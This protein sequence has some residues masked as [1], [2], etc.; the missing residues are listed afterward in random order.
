MSTADENI[1]KSAKCPKCSQR[2]HIVSEVA[3]TQTQFEK[4]PRIPEPR[5]QEPPFID[6][7]NRS[8]AVSREI[9][10]SK[11]PEMTPRLPTLA[12]FI[13]GLTYLLLGFW[14]IADVHSFNSAL[15]NAKAAPQEAAIGAIFAA[16]FIAGYIFAR[17]IEKFI[18]MVARA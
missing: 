4:E 10:D 12:A 8:Q 1:G 9:P 18:R 3:P 6:T 5:K 16:R 15:D 14:I 11:R 7:T 13:I 2:G 17:S